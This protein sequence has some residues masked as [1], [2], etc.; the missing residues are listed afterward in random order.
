MPTLWIVLGIAVV[1]ILFAVFSYNRLVSYRL[2]FLRERKEK[3]LK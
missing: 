3:V 1:V 2:H